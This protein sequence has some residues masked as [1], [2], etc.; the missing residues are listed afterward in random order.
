MSYQ[1]NLGE[2]LQDAVR[3]IVTERVDY[4]IEQLRKRK[5]DRDKQIHEARKSFKQIR[6]VLRLIRGSLDKEIYNQENATYRDAGQKL[7]TLRDAF[8]RIATLD[9]ALQT[10]NNPEAVGVAKVLRQSLQQRY[11][12]AHHDL[13]EDRTAV[14]EVIA[15]LQEAKERIA[16]WELGESDFT[17]LA[18]G[19]KKN[20]RQG[21][22]ALK[23]AFDG[24]YS[25]EAFHDWR[26]R[27]KYLWNQMRVLAPLNE[28][29]LSPYVDQLDALGDDLG[30]ANDLAVLQES[31]RSEE[32][33]ETPGG[34]ILL[35]EL[36]NQRLNLLKQTEEPG[37]RIFMETPRL[38]VARLRGYYW[39]QQQL[40]QS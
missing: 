39:M 30:L 31:L 32:L 5:G 28:P 37:Q 9:K 15:V 19:L 11:D 20:Y 34:Q 3:R 24:E 38:F 17:L 21:V 27:T 4:A 29:M 13:V 18:P 7:G 8:V 10:I 12:E 1:L 25:V 14:N 23:T 6:A 40:Q 22:G 33:L 16:Q 2:N 26:K 35:Q 36:E